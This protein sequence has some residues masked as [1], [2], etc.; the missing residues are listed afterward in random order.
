MQKLDYNLARPL[1]EDGDIG[2][3]RRPNSAIALSGRSEDSH[4]WM[5]RWWGKHLMVLEFV[6]WR[7]GRAV[8]AA[9]RIAGL[10]DESI[11]VLRPRVDR[12][13]RQAAA[14]SMTAMVGQAY[15]WRGIVAAAV[16]RIWPLNL[17]VRPNFDETADDSTARKFRPHYCSAGVAIAYR[18]I[19]LVARRAPSQVEPADLGES[20]MLAYQFTIGRQGALLRF[21]RQEALRS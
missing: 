20:S 5:F 4:A 7:G 2:L 8:T 21:G 13:F 18:P 16:M 11:D 10:P 1:I 17:F 9:A 6:E 15:D 12:K 19:E 3:R 14:V